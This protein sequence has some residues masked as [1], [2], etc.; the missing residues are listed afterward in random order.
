MGLLSLVSE[1]RDILTAEGVNATVRLGL[2]EPARKDNQSTG[3]G[4]R[5]CF[6]PVGGPYGS[7][8]QPGRNPRPLFTWRASCRVH[9]WGYD[10]TD[11][12]DEEKQYEATWALHDWVI[13]ALYRA[14]H[15][16]VQMQNSSWTSSPHNQHGK[17]V[18]LNIEVEVPVLET[19]RPTAL[20]TAE[21]T[22][23]K[24]VKPDGTVIGP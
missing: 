4:N 21:N 15:G 10:G 5:V 17:E 6:V 18:V 1:V 23:I 13:R 3:T 22:D 16:T 19:P 20:I 11:P 12:T 2:R 24:L 14:K 9:I 8:K 7:A